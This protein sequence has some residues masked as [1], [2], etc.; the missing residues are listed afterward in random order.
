MIAIEPCLR[1]K[2]Q[3]LF[4]CKA[5][6]DGIPDQFAQGSEIHDTVQED[7]VGDFVFE[8]GKS[9]IEIE[10]DKMFANGE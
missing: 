2:H 3:L 1:C 7:Q 8:E 6:P 5:Y 4:G 9:D 10:R